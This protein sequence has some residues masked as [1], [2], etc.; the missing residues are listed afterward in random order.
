MS[1]TK[2]LQMW[3][4]LVLHDTEKSSEDGHLELRHLQLPLLDPAD[5]VQQDLHHI[6]TSN[7]QEKLASQFLEND[8]LPTKCFAG[9]GAMLEDREGQLG[10]GLENC[11][12]NV[13][14]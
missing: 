7:Y 13:Q 2:V 4:C 12:D 6:W 8:I 1:A 11:I 14:R 10:T 5:L 3:S 9:S